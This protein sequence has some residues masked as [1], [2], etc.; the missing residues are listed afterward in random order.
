MTPTYKKL[1]DHHYSSDHTRSGYVSAEDLYKEIGY[2]LEELVK[3]N[4]GYSNTCAVRVSLALLKAGVAFKGRLPVKAGPFKGKMIEPGAKLLAD[5]LK[6]PSVI[7]K[8]KYLKPEDAS[9]K[10]GMKRGVVFFWKIVDYGG[11]HIDLIETV[12][13]EQQCNSNCYFSCKEVWFWELR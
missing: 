10:I 8:P 13:M 2:T 7:G 3:Q 6:L 1:R 9:A 5:Q 11:G 4:A 12:T